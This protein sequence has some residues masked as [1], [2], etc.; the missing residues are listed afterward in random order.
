MINM[1]K[2]PGM[3]PREKVVAKALATNEKKVANLDLANNLDALAEAT[4]ILQELAYF[5]AIG[6]KVPEREM[7][8]KFEEVADMF[9]DVAKQFPK[10]VSSNITEISITIS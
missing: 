7:R 10:A 2:K 3:T 6:V 5:R 4:S 8:A 1:A 9:G